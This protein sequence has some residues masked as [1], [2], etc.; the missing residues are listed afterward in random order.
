VLSVRPGMTD[1][2]SIVYIRET[3]LLAAQ[4]DPLA[5]YRRVVLPHKLAYCRFYVR[6]ASVRLDLY[7][8]GWTIVV[9]TKEAVGARA[10]AP[11]G[12]SWFRRSLSA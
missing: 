3:E 1:F 2:A 4:P 12:R 5:Y 9:L 10:A 6:H 11:H 7:L 8:I